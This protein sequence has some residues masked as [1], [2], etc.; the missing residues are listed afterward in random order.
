VQNSFSLTCSA[1]G[2][3]NSISVSE[4]GDETELVRCARCRNAI[5]SVGKLHAAAAQE[6]IGLGADDLSDDH[7]PPGGPPF[8]ETT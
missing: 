6:A 7:V 4:A 5:T 3:V 2:E 1:C 8:G